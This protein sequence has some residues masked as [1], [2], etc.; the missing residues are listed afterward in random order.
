MRA[1]L[2]VPAPLA[3]PRPLSDWRPALGC[4]EGL[5]S[6]KKI[7]RPRRGGALPRAEGD[8]CCRM[9]ISPGFPAAIGQQPNRW[10]KPTTMIASLVS[11][12]R[13]TAAPDSG[14]SEVAH[15][16]G[17]GV[18]NGRGLRRGCGRHGGSAACSRGIV[19]LRANAWS[20]EDQ[21]LWRGGFPQ[22]L[23]PAWRS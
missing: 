15:R 19:W 16:P 10:D 17:F 4:R 3:T 21:D 13:D 2:D 23:Q 14:E 18:K 12:G 7:C 22:N 11:E 1:S 8:S 5:Q 20:F 6:R 9:A